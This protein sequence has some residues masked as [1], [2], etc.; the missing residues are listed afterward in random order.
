MPYKSD[1]QRKF[2]HTD[3]AKKEGIT[4]AEVKEFDQASKGKEL[5]EH[6]KKMADGGE[7]EFEDAVPGPSERLG[8]YNGKDGKQH[9]EHVMT[10]ADG[11]VAEDVTDAGA[12]QIATDD[13]APD[14]FMG[15]LQVGIKNGIN[16]D[17]DAVKSYLASKFSQLLRPGMGEGQAPLAQPQMP[18]RQDGSYHP[19]DEPINPQD[20][21]A[22]HLAKGGYPHVTFMENQTPAENEKTTHLAK[23]P[24]KMAEGGAIHKAEDKNKEPA[25][26]AD[27]NMSH[28]KK[29]SAIYKAMGIKKYSDGGTPTGDVDPSQ[30][31]TPSQ[32][33]PGYWDKIKDALSQVG[34]TLGSALPTMPGVAEGAANAASTPGIAPAVNA[35]LGTNLEGPA[36][37]PATAAPAPSAP[38]VMPPAAPVKLPTGPTVGGNTA[39]GASELNNLFNQDTSKLTEGVNAEDRNALVNKIGTQQHGLGAII[40]QAVSGLGDALAAKGGKEQHSL[41][42]IFSMQKEQRDEALANFDKARQDRIQKLALQTQ[43]GNNS[44]QK[45]AAQDAYGVDD[46][47][48]TMLGAPTG[49]AHKDLPL[50]FQMKSAQVA[51]QEKDAD[52]YM[53]A[54]SQAASDVDSAVKNAS[55]LNVKPSS[56]QLQASG[57]KLAD[58]YYNRAKGNILVKPSDGGQAQ[59]I[60][61]QNLSKAKQMDPNLTV[62]P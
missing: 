13:S 3:T 11:G 7:A 37:I 15:E 41:Q 31:P 27:I 39:P 5:P 61:A 19:E 45:L 44:I 54:H 56:A 2:F 60:P 16:H 22:D 12:K 62:Q 57:A 30:L 42:G 38:P 47:L 35:A 52:L 34:S 48:N 59:W 46:H 6:T 43:M 1:A 53:K 8:I 4:N 17:S 51:Q 40:A 58:Q 21:R 14:K 26:P 36:A 25:K 24:A 28:E 49:T 32:N 29:L 33:D 10:A 20:P 23:G 9:A 55:V 50:Y 18:N